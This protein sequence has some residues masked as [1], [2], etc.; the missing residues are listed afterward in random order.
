MGVGD[1]AV[2]LANDLTVPAGVVVDVYDTEGCTRLDT[3]LDSG[4][5]G[6]KVGC[7]KST[8][9]LVVD[10]VLPA[11]WETEGV[12]AGVLDEVVHLVG[13][14]SGWVDNGA[15]C[16]STVGSTSKVESIDVLEKV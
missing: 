11:N 3:V 10:Q 15:G 6:G 8:T 2:G 13:T 4:I 12:Q 9:K 1:G 14:C 7:I 5:V 16:A